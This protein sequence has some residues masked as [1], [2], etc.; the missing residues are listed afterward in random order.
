MSF[1]PISYAFGDFNGDG[2]TDIQAD[3]LTPGAAVD[4]KDSGSFANGLSRFPAGLN[5]VLLNTTPA[6][7]F[8]LA[9]AASYAPGPVATGSIVAAFGSGLATSTAAATTVPLPLTLGG[10]SVTVTDSAGTARPAPL[11]YASPTQV[12]FAIPDG[13]AAGEASVAIASGTSM[14][15]IQKPVWVAPGL[16]GVNGVAVGNV[17]TYAN[18]ASTPVVSN[19]FSVSSTGEITV[20]PI[21]VGAGST[22]VFLVLYGTG[23]RNHA[24]A[25]TATIGSTTVPAA[26]AGPQNVFVGEDQ[27]NI[28]WITTARIHAANPA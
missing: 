23:I 22:Q 8:V 24:A 28:P 4:L 14:L 6:V 17:L 5:E 21:D 1:L 19:T 27:I 7:K 25:V 18:G 15:T 3:A 13:T 12:N 11:F 26:Y 2:L 16:F 9:D 10:A 20:V